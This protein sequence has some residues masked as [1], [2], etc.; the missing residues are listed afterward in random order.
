MIEQLHVALGTQQ[1]ITQFRVVREID[2]LLIPEVCVG[3][4]EGRGTVGEEK[5]AGVKVAVWRN[6]LRGSSLEVGK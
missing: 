2:V 1:P 5:R 6:H 3:V 4:H